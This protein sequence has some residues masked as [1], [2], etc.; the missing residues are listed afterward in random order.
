MKVNDTR[1]ARGPGPAKPK[2]KE[3]TGDGPGFADHLARTTD[4]PDGVEEP[5]EVSAVVGVDGVLAAQSV[6]EDGGGAARR[7]LVNRGEDIL[8]RLDQLRL[9]ILRGVVSKERLVNLA[10]LL[11]ARRMTVEDPSL[12]AVIDEI[13]LRAEVEIAKLSRRDP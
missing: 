9:D 11:R 13:E 12:L 1:A 3:S 10:T 4:A 2:K 7:A 6:D 5:S 8:D